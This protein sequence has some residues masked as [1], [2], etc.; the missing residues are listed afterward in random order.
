MERDLLSHVE[1]NAA[2]RVIV[3][4]GKEHHRHVVPI[5]C[6][7]LQLTC[8]GRLV[9]DKRERYWRPIAAAISAAKADVGVLDR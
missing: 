7:Q 3:I 8:D 1:L 9:R 6:N 5:R 2:R 4:R